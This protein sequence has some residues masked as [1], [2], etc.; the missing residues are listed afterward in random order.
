MTRPADLSTQPGVYEVGILTV[1]FALDS[2]HA[3]SCSRVANVVSPTA[4]P[5]RTR[6]GN[7]KFSISTLKPILR[8]CRLL[9]F[10]PCYILLL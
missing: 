3:A 2:S 9:N 5:T 8:I 7:V 6:S 1:A 4:A 10:P